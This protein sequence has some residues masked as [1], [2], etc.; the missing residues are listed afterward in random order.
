M[1]LMLDDKVAV[2]TGAGKGIGLAITEA[3]SPKA[4]SS[5]PARAP[6]P[7]STASTG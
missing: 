6:P 5:S 2:V 4:R 7:A 3:S 1:D